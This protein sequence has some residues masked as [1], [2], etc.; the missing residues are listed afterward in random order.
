MLQAM[1]EN[2]TC[3]KGSRL[4]PGHRGREF[5]LLN[6][7]HNPFLMVTPALETFDSPLATGRHLTE[8]KLLTLLPYSQ[9]HRVA[10]LVLGGHS[11]I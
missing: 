11:T 10:S 6:G 7:V 2:P 5:S 4:I 3:C 9:Y 1:Q 8:R